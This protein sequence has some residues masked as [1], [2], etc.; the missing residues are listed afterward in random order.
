[1]GCTISLSMVWAERNNNNTNVQMEKIETD[2]EIDCD[3][4]WLWSNRII[5]IR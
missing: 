3:K 2:E 5:Y 1:M 4:M